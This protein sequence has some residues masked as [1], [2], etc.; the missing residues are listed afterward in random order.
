MSSV[1]VFYAGG[2]KRSKTLAEAAYTGLLRIGERPVLRDSKSYAR[3]ESDY[4]VF[5]GLACGLD[6][7]FKDYKAQ[8]TAVY[9]DLGYWHRRLRTRYDGYHKVV[10]NSRHPTAYFQ[11]NKH[12]KRRF[13]EL[14]LIVRPWQKAKAGKILLASMSQK[15][16]IAEGLAPF[17][18]ERNALANILQH[19]ERTI[20]YRPKPNCPRAR[21]LP[22]SHFDKKTSLPITLK[23]CHAVVTR[24]SNTAVDALINGVPVFCELG[25][26]SVM[27]H[28]D[29]SLIES[30]RYPDNRQQWAEDIAWTQFTTAEI[31]TGL[32]FSHLKNEG[33][34]P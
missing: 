31:S 8:A 33:L 5:Y 2:N 1:S 25:V 10:V 32:P 9:I 19:T 17:A 16:A 11:N 28:S 22:G 29:L 14:G 15:A 3:V 27:G 30:P 21:P 24:Q 4:A 34:I 13:K 23:G 18:W 26:S 6:K 12:D 7:I 20:T